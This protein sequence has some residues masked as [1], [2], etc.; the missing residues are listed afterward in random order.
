MRPC[1]HQM[2]QCAWSDQAEL[3]DGSNEAANSGIQIS[4]N[5]ESESAELSGRCCVETL[6][7]ATLWLH[8][9]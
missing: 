6:A 7:K 8:A 3:A 4:S 9:V 5:L 2:A 1:A